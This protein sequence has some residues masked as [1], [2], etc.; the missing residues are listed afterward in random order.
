MSRPAR[1]AVV[2]AKSPSG[3]IERQKASVRFRMSLLLIAV[4]FSTRLVLNRVSAERRL[5]SLLRQG[6]LT[7]ARTG[8]IADGVSNGRG[9]EGDGGLARAHRLFVTS[10]DEHRFHF[11]EGEAERKASVGCPVDRSHLSL[12]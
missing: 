3:I 1:I 8:G 10:I 7:D 12:V 4:S 11:R 9:G 6:H 5:H 2:W